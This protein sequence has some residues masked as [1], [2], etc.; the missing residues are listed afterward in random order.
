MIGVKLTISVVVFLILLIII[1]VII[2]KSL[3]PKTQIAIKF[4]QAPKWYER[5]CLAVGLLAILSVIGI[6]YST[7]YLLY[8]Y[9]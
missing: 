3:D 7:I 9:L 4:D 8:V 2:F 5:Y 6:I 1:G